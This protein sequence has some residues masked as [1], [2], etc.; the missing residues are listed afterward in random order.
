MTRD[1]AD[2]LFKAHVHVRNQSV[3]LR[4]IND[5]FKSMHEL[6]KYLSYINIQPYSIYLHDMLSGAEE[7]RTTLASAI[8]LEKQLR[9]ST[10]GFNMPQFVVDLPASGGKRLVSSF[11]TYNRDTGISVFRSPRMEE[12]R[13]TYRNGTKKDLFFYFDPLHTV[14]TKHQ[15]NGVDEFVK[16]IGELSK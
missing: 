4:G 11:E 6:I 14:T 16:L 7:F 5:D 9:G 1:A 2:K 10:A 12:S 3:L 8:E 15:Q 13:N